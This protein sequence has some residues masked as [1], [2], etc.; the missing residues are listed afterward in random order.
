MESNMFCLYLPPSRNYPVPDSV[1]VRQ[2][3]TWPRLHRN[4]SVPMEIPLYEVQGG[5]GIDMWSDFGESAREV[6]NEKIFERRTP[7]FGLIDNVTIPCDGL[8]VDKINDDE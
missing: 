8:T 3:G 6:K 5:T 2:V 7:S 1:T 4:S